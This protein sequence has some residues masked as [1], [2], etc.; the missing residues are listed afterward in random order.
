MTLSFKNKADISKPRKR[1]SV[2]RDPKLNKNEQN[3]SLV[4]M[5]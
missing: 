3:E 1:M 2:I 4:P 5:E